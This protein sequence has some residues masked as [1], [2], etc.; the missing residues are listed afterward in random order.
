MEDKI[1][2]KKEYTDTQ[3]CCFMYGLVLLMMIVLGSPLGVSYILDETGTV[4]NSAF[5]AGYNWNDWVNCTGGYFYKYGQAIF[6]FPILKLVSNPYLIYK[7]MLFVNG[8]ILAWIPVIAYTILRKHLKQE[9]KAK[10]TLA[11]L[12]ISVIPATVLY[13]LYARADVMLTA[14]AWITLYVVLECMEAES[15]KKR[16]VLS[17]LIAFVSVYMYMCHSRGIVFVI[18]VFMV[19]FVIRFLMKNKHICFSAYVISLVVWM[20]TDDKLTHY[21]KNS[22]WGSGTKKNTL[23]NVNVD[24]YANLL[25]AGGIETVIKNVTGW[26]FNTFLGTYGLAVLGIAFALV[27]VVCYITRKKDITPKEAVISLYSVLVY[28]G[29]LAM[30][31]L[32]SFGSNY[33][34]VIG[35]KVKRA[36]RFLY[37]R[38]IA[39]AYALLI[40]IALYYLFFKKDCFGLKTKFA[41]LGGSGVLI[42]Y[43][44]TWLKDFVNHVEYSWRNTI[45]SALF[46]DTVRYG[47][48]ANQYSNVSRALLM[49]AILA[50]VVL[51]IVIVLGYNYDSIKRKNLI[52]V[53]VGSCFLISLSVNYV[54]L[55]LFTDVRPMLAVGA[56]ITEMDRIEDETNISEIY[57]D[58]YIDKTVSRYKMMQLAMP[59][60]TVHVRSSVSAEEVNNMFI[61]VENYKVNDAWMGDDCYLIKDYD[62]ENSRTTVIV[63]GEKLRKELENRGIA[64]E[65]VPKDYTTKENKAGGTPALQALKISLKY[66][67]ES[68]N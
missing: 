26:L 3:I 29:T 16:I 37:S 1:K 35:E 50:F 9:D 34:F 66:Q 39:P 54:K 47:N 2:V 46:F 19:V 48:D 51:Y 24:K 8:V 4:A 17:V 65:P 42:I 27:G 52:F 41:A 40:L 57:N 23:E 21:F 13:S 62:F 22:I 12:C 63:K 38:Y 64:L 67:L 14:F 45:D 56:S 59:K 18:A 25:T 10:C 58:V 43:C 6:Y 68:F 20:Y 53:F 7:L 5:L 33:K 49:A 32:F 36:D 15:R 28:F 11:S 31:V 44:R 55:R 30:S 61:I 60:Y